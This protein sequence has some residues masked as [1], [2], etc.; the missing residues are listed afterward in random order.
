MRTLKPRAHW[1]SIALCM[2]ALGGCVD[3]REAPTQGGASFATGAP[4]TSLDYQAMNPG[5][6]GAGGMGGTGVPAGAGGTAGLL[7]MAGMIAD[8]TAGTGGVGGTGGAGGMNT[9]AGAGGTQ[10]G[11]SG[12]DGASGVGG[13]SGIE[14]TGGMGDAG[15][16]GGTATA[17]SLMVDF[18]SVGNSGEYAPRNVGAVWIETSSG[19][20]VKTIA[21]WAGTRAGHLTRW[22]AASGGW[23]GGFFFA[24][25]GNPGDEMDAVSSATLRSHQ[26]HTLTWNMHDVNG[27]IVA[28]G[29]Y[30]LVIEVTESE[31]KA[32]SV[33]E[34]DF[35]KGA[36]PVSL[37]PSD[38]G[39]YSGLTLTYS[40]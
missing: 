24:T 38:Q 27:A 7:P 6:G 21:R 8:P 1:W 13:A 9:I 32:S 37:S 23:G 20:F 26:Q 19:T 14:P 4:S 40:P 36:A 30:K 25:G 5:Q 10:S 22:T 39:P 18:M 33:A 11:G 29:G 34:I 3:A 16:G 12:G 2:A 17:G 35:E 31:R 15:S 28:D